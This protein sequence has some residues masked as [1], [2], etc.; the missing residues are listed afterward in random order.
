MIAPLGQY[1]TSGRRKTTLK[2]QIPSWGMV[3]QLVHW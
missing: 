3:S 1:L 2:G